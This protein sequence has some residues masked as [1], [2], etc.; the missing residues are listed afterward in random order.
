MIYAEQGYEMKAVS[1][2]EQLRKKGMVVEYGFFDQLEL[3]REYARERNIGKIVI[4][5]KEVTEVE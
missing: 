5:D 4:V 3:V 2:A 1:V